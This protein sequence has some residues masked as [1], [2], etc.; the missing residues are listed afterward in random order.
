[1]WVLYPSMLSWPLDCW[2]GRRQAWRGRLGPP[3]PP[4]PPTSSAHSLI[5]KPTIYILNQF[6]LF[7]NKSRC[8]TSNKICWSRMQTEI[9]GMNASG[10]EAGIV[11]N[12]RWQQCSYEINA[13][14]PN[15]IQGFS[16]KCMG[17]PGVQVVGHLPCPLGDPLLLRWP[18]CDSKC[19]VSLLLISEF[20]KNSTWF[21]H[22]NLSRYCKSLL[23][24]VRES[25]LELWS[26]WQ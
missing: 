25:I 2:V 24:Q 15:R 7:L 6:H 1:M 19:S 17:F 8:E 20:F 10:M 9:W 3:S 21:C 26:W 16:H 5:C 13:D 23:C 4:H 11:R 12:E 22:W 14:G 18:C